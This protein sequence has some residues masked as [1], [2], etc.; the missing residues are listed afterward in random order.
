MVNK[1]RY[2]HNQICTKDNEIVIGEIYDYEEDD[3][4]AEVKI[5]K[6]TSD[7]DGI[8]F[9]CKILRQNYKIDNEKIFNCW[10][11]NGHYGYNGM[12]R[13]YDRGTYTNR[14]KDK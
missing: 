8:G 9:D 12:W 14:L 3:W 1:M 4:I 7:K 11:A 6:D 13:L 10:A 5:I 2:E